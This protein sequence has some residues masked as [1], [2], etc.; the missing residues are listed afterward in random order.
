M[1]INHDMADP[2]LSPAKSVLLAVHVARKGQISTLRTLVSHYRKTLHTELVL[3]ILLSH[4]PETLDSSDY[5]PFLGDLA[6]DKVDADSK[7]TV[8]VSFLRDL[9]EPEA[10]KKVRNL[11]LLPLLWPDAPKDVPAEP[12]ILFLIHRSL[13][14]DLNTGLITQIPEL[15][16]PFLHLSSYLRTWAIST[17]L[18]LLRLNYEYHPE[19]ATF[20][21][22]TRFEELTDRA[23]VSLLLASTGTARTNEPTSDLTVGRDLRGLIGP[24]MYGDTRTKRRKLRRASSFNLQSLTPLEDISAA[25]HKYLGWEEVFMWMTE[26][27]RTSWR[28][29]VEAVEQ[30]DGPGDVDLGGWEDGTMWLDEEDQQHLEARYARSMLA[31]AFLIAEESEAAL[32]GV[33]RVLVRIVTLLDQDR[34]PTLEAACALLTPVPTLDESNILSDKNCP[35]L[36]N[37]L[38]D[39]NNPLTAPRDE[40]IRLLHALLISAFLCTR[41]KYPIS[42]RRAGELA[43]LQDEHEQRTAFNSLMH[44]IGKGPID[45]DKYWI[46]ARNEL[47]WLWNWGAEELSDGSVTTKGRGVFGRL[48]RELIEVEIF[49]MFLTNSSKCLPS[50]HRLFQI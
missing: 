29:A 24:W 47:L 45:N 42:I 36:R 7:A 48:P 19:E 44:Y 21:T 3:R 6:S 9:G 50:P 30:W 38:L 41:A 46:R 10:K 35:Y 15:I 25:N 1:Q 32:D 27:A 49:K 23:G 31:T 14:I 33:Q 8:D 20:L 18:P 28:T 2:E 17:V 5:V 37:D 4:L 13:R 26:K 16:A 34:I 22:I 39:D 11:G 43:I 12:F 40:S